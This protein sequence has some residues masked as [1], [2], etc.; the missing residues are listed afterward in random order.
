MNR[1][2]LLAQCQAWYKQDE[3]QKIIDALEAIPE[4]K[5]TREI[6]M[7]LARAYNNR[8]VSEEPVNRAMLK[9]AI[10]LMEPYCFEL[11]EDY[12]WNVLMGFAHYYLEQEGQ[13]RWYF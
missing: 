6:D 9:C 8:A 12:S 3:Y 11:E 2:E 5:R 13:A 10:A 4:K 7:E 1:K